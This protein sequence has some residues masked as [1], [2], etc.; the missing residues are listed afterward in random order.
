M[1]LY[2]LLLFFSLSTFI[3]SQNK[4]HDHNLDQD[5]I[6]EKLK[7][8]QFYFDNDSIAGFNEEAAWQLARMGTAPA[9]EQKIH[10]A[11]LKRNY[12]NDKYNLLPQYSVLASPQ[13]AC[14]NVDFETGD[15]SGWTITQGMNT[16]SITHAGCC[17]AASTR[18]SVVG[19]GFDP[20]LG[21]TVLATVPPNGGN[22]TLKLGDGA[23]ATGHAVKARQTFAVTTTNSVFVYRYAVVLEDAA[24]A[25]T[26]QPYFNISFVDASS[27][28]IPCTDF[29][30]VAASSSCNTGT[31]PSFIDVGLY[32]YKDWTTKS[33][34]LS[35]YIGQNV[36]IE[37]IASDC[38]QT[39]HA[40]W[41]YIDCSCAPLTLNLNGTDIPVGQTNNNMCSVGTNTLCAPIGFKA[42]SWTGPGVTGQTGQCVN[43]SSLGTYSVNLTLE[44]VSCASPTLYSNFA[45]VPP[46]I[47][48]FTFP[49][50]ACQSTFTVPFTSNINLNGGSAITSYNWDFNKDGVV[51]NTIPN[52]TNNFGAF[53]TYTAQLTVSN[54]ACTSVKTKTLS[55]NPAPSVTVTG[56]ASVCSGSC[57]VLNGQVLEPAI[58][59]TSSPTFSVAPGT[60]ISSS[61][62]TTITSS[63]NVSGLSSATLASVC[64]NI[65]HTY[66]GDLKIS[67]VCPSGTTLVLSNAHGGSGD[68]YTNTCFTP[69]ATNVIGSTGNNAAPF[70]GTYKPDGAGGLG[71]LSGCALNGIWT[72][73]VKDNAGGDG[74]ALL[75]WSL[76]FNNSSTT[77]PSPTYTW[78]PS[79]TSASSVLS[80]TVCPTSTTIYSLTTT[81]SN[82]C[83]ATQTA[84]VTINPKPLATTTQTNPTCGLSNGSVL[85]SNTSPALPAQTITSYTSSLG[86]MSGQTVTGL[87]ASSPIIT[88]TNNFGCTFTISPT[89]TNGAGPTAVVLT[90]SNTTCGLTNGTLAI[91]AVTGGTS[92]YTYS[93]N[94]VSST[95]LSTGLAVGTYTVLVR[96]VN[97]CT[98]T[99]TTSISNIAGPTALAGNTS[100]ATCAGPTG[101]FTVTS[102]TGGTPTYSFAVDANALS[103]SSVT[104]G[105][106]VGSH[107]VKVK[108]SNACT[109]TTTITV[110]VI[111]GITS[112]TVV[113]SLATCGSAN[114][115]STVTGVTGGTPTY[116]YSYDG[117]G[118]TTTATT[119]GLAAGSHTVIIKDA[120][121]CTLT[122][123]YTVLNN[124]SPTSTVTGFT[125]PSCAGSSTGSF[126]LSASGGSGA[127]FTYT[128]TTPYATSSTGIFSA[129]PQGTFNIT[130]RDAG[131][132]TTTN[133]VVLTDP[134]P[135]AITATASPVLCF[136]AATGSIAVTGSGGTPTYSYNLNGNASYQSSANFTSQLAG[137]Y[138]MGVKDSKGCTTTQTVQVTQ[139]TALAISVSSQSANCT[140]A[141]GVGSATVTGGT[142]AIT[143]SWTGGG[144]TAAV[145]NGVVTG[146]YTVTA[147]DANN[148][149]ITSPVLVGQTLGGTAAITASSDVTCFNAADGSLTAGMT[150]GGTSPYSY[151]WNSSP[152]QTVATAINLA[153]GSYTCT[154]TDFYGCIATAAGTITQP[155]VLSLNMSSNNVKCFG[156][157]TGTVSAIG[158]GGTAPYSYL[159]ATIPSTLSTVNNVALGTYSCTVTDANNCTKTQ[160]IVV[161]EPTP[162][163]LTST[164]T[165]ANCNQANGSA[166]VTAS[167][168]APGAY[169][170]SWSAGSTT[171]NQ[172]SVAAGTYTILVTDANNC[173]QT[174]ASTIPNLSG[175]SISISSQT[176][177]SCFGGNDGVAT[178]T[179]TGG[180]LPYVY[181]W[182]N[183]N[184]SAIAT[185]LSN[186]VYT[187]SVTDAAG[188][189]AS[190]NV[191]IIQP[192]V[193]TLS[194]IPTQPTCF[195][196]TNGYGIASANGG[197]SPYTYTWTLGGGNASTSTQLGANNYGLTATDSKGCVVSSSMALVNP[198][199]MSASISYTNVTCFGACNAT[200][201]ATSL[202]GVGAVSYYWTGGPNP[203]TA[204]T[205]SNICIGNYTV[206][207]TDQNSCTAT[208]NVTIIEPSALTVSI[209][210]TG[211]ITCPGGTNGFASA[212][213]SGGTGAYTYSW[214]PSGGNTANAS[215]LSAG[216]YTVTVKDANNCSVST[217]TTIVEPTPLA[218]TLTVTNPNCNGV[219]DG[220]G[221][222]AFSG[223]T[224]ATTFLW[225]PGLQSGN[226]VP[227]LCAGNQTVTITFNGSCVTALTFTLTEPAVLTA[228]ATASNSN[229]G[230][231]N[232]NTCATVGGGTLPYAFLWSNGATTLCNN[233]ILAGAYTFTVTDA[234]NCTALAGGLV[235]DISGPVVAVTSQTNITCFGL[236][237]GAATATISGGVTPYNITWTGIMAST[238]NTVTTNTINN[239][240]NFGDGLHLITV[241]DAANCVGTASVDI[242]QP[243]QI[244]SAIV[245]FT[246]VSCF[247]LSDGGAD[248]AVNGGTGPYTYTWTPSNQSSAT[249]VNTTAADYTVQVKD[250]KGC[251]TS[252]PVTIVEPPALVM[253]VTSYTDI[254]C[255]GSNNGQIRTQPTGGTPGY[256]YS[257]IPAIPGNSGIVSGLGPNTYTLNVVDNHNCSVTKT[258]II[259]EPTVLTSTY[260]SL[261]ATC[262][263]ANGSATVSILGGTPG[264]NV[265]W[266]LPG[267]PT[268]PTATAMQP[269]SGWV[270]NVT[271]AHGCIITQTVNVDAPPIPVITGFTS[272]PPT[273]FGSSNGDVTINYASGTG[274][275][276][277]AWSSP[278]SQTNTSAALTQSVAGISAGVYTATLT[279]S[280]GCVA[281]MPTTVTQPNI[282]VLVV[283]PPSTICYGQSTQLNAAGQG[284]T[285]AYSYTW[286]PNP[287]V[288]GGPHNVTPTTTTIYTVSVSDTKGCQPPNKTIV[289]SV[290]PP[291]TATGSSVALCDGKVTALTP[292]ITSPG[293]GAPYFYAWS[294]GSTYTAAISSENVVANFASTPNTYTVFI[295]DGCSIPTTAVFTVNVN[296][297]PVISFTSNILAGCAPLTVTLTGTSTGTDNSFGWQSSFYVGNPQVITFSD[298]G[299]HTIDLSVTNTV[300]GCSNTTNRVDYIW[301]YPVPVA[302]FY[303]NPA[304]ASILDPNISF[305]NTSEGAAGYYWDFGDP[306]AING[307]NT[308]IITN[309]S[310]GY[311]YVGPYNVNMIAT[312][313]KGCKDT[314]M[315]VV[316]IMPDFAIY[317]PNAFTPDANG[318]ND[319]FQP[320]GV[321]IDEDRYRLDIFDRWGEDVFSSTTFRKGW[322]GSVKGSSRMAPQGVYTY[323]ILIY[324]TQGNK[325]PFVGHVTLIKKES[326]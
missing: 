238:N 100:S 184:T 240:I 44:G 109:Y 221:N 165:P 187:V 326:N 282:L 33:F 55:I 314:V 265:V 149:V 59:T 61:S 232:G 108:D 124:G 49:S 148:C 66:D 106:A 150:I 219:C 1:K 90:P 261:P 233:N 145:S 25:C 146:N 199:A 220:T 62:A 177:V 77:N 291:L 286:S 321:G 315:H 171:N 18:F 205:L 17:A 313:S 312:S 42:Y 278:I 168:G 236:L 162:L 135:V 303:A 3:F 245:S 281:S 256:T 45:L 78:A 170:Y 300:T 72:L 304:Q 39:A 227:N 89:L 110:G 319:I 96:D 298:T 318:L 225:Q 325:H 320:M 181:Q 105:L 125:N 197:T 322:D 248:V 126:S 308:S 152:V 231:S 94:G 274:P 104:S 48:D 113:P 98:Y 295:D 80:P 35:A 195:G 279:D 166:T 174:L 293:K 115:T 167:G 235:N 284:G 139:P 111:A 76:N 128:L 309:P 13:A 131:G 263:L 290:T 158:S 211:S 159:W 164:V 140:A 185:N 212:S 97:G 271:D 224:G 99:Q 10:V 280:Y 223:G 53:G 200:A 198:P 209:P 182:S 160:S 277:V 305:V 58:T 299:K 38:K 267:N 12:I 54:G 47:A 73:I 288:G 81:A 228:V 134:A 75:N 194:I 137:I 114:G 203:I 239:P 229:C 31:D 270:A 262:G 202:N 156:T 258:F 257:W 201:T 316:E 237:D 186:N 252:Q 218:T 20:T 86:V 283:D 84:V 254:S 251:L 60:L 183:G 121:T 29:N 46:P 95:T 307:T 196:A 28:P 141:N 67:L 26:D 34:D 253:G 193:L 276:T 132:C 57:V 161:N 85:I 87:S 133:S 255:F 7:N 71:A 69:T 226:N 64:L 32:F 289:I 83:T 317:I 122:V 50:V 144:G 101:S 116:S 169:T 173:T 118:F 190:T 136:G 74:G 188:C 130:I 2:F 63:I 210:S 273:C 157:A 207:A 93:V 301:V 266:N 208:A 43:V 324:D 143:Y 302:S 216:I 175:P 180:T 243:T 24:H 120:N 11:N 79:V 129:L 30:V 192:S 191:N 275:Y 123:P 119:T 246:N 22:F 179:T 178:A 204:Q 112:A 213:P 249:L 15:A 19:P 285:P 21:G 51:D 155:P 68:N 127:P 40:G 272:T 153:P 259:L 217:S 107:T 9:W 8:T 82:G 310:H 323:K 154:I 306:V 65:N 92:P 297:N 189:V 311:T 242:T 176:N 6:S 294:T 250:S 23:T 215:S 4:K 147:T 138:T 230:Q 222:V 172:G 264:Y 268:G 206:L 151:S 296:P 91:G 70:T 117:G 56:S 287:F 5:Y 37:F 103:T 269:G 142:G 52:P 27:N 234:K 214:L 247:G 41:A 163:V 260:S 88:L 244:A 102:V 16:N 241:T 36:T 292:N 14:T